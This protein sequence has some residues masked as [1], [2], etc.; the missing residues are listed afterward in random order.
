M[1][2]DSRHIK[3]SLAF[4]STAMLALLAAVIIGCIAALQFVYPH[5][6]VDL[7]FV[8][9][10]PLH[11]SLAVAWIFLSATGGIYYYLPRFG[12]LQWYSLRWPFWQLIII[13][14]TGTGII[15]CYATGIF[16]GREYWEHPVWFS[17]PIVFS[18]LLLLIN[19]FKTIFKTTEPWPVY[20]WMWAT[21]ILFFL[22]T[23]LESNLWIFPYF[24]NHLIRDLTVQWKSYGALVGSWN[25][26]VYG[27]AAFLAE[28]LTGNKEVS[29]SRTAFL[30]YFLGFTNLLFGWAHHTYTVPS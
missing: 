22:L 30:L 1:K 20:V 8:R 25:M 17:I 28:K 21:G 6:A 18:W 14:F 2:N 13:L 29:R 3:I 12:N 4:I 7:G 27:T 24:R 23:F 5:F 9:S 16:G 10:R 26:L 15:I 11:V 19:F